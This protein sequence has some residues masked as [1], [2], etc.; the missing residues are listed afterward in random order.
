MRTIQYSVFCTI[1]LFTGCRDTLQGTWAGEFECQDRTYDVS[2]QFV[3]DGRYEF[4]GEMIFSYDEDATFGGES[5]LFHAD[6]KYD[7]TTEQTA[8]A[9]GQNYRLTELRVEHQ[10]A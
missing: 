1:I 3:E 2:A 8:I 9:G 6:L 7:F 10:C 5:V 4:D